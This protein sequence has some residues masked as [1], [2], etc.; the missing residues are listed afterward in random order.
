MHDPT[1][2]LGERAPLTE[3]DLRLPRPPGV[4]RRFW[5]RH[6]WWVDGLVAGAYL[7]VTVVITIASATT[8][9]PVPGAVLVLQFAAVAVSAAALMLRR[10]YPA[11]VLGVVWVASFALITPDGAFNSLAVPMALYALAVYR[12]SRAGWVGFAASVVAGSASALAASLMHPDAVTSMGTTVLGEIVQVTIVLLVAVL[13]GTNIGN[14]RRYVAALVD[15]ANQLARER[16]QQ[17]RLAASAERS[18]IARE[19]HDIVSHS[20]TVMVTVAEGSAATAASAPQR[21]SE[22]MRQVAET[23]RHALSDMRRMLGVLHDDEPH[24]PRALEPQPGV[25]DV[26]ALVQ[27]FRAVSLPVTYRSSGLPP[28]DAAVQLTMYRIVQESLTNALRHAHGVTMAAVEVRHTSSHTVISVTDD[29]VGSAPSG[30]GH[31]LVGMRERVALYGGT[32]E[33]GPAPGHGWSI[34]ATLPHGE[35]L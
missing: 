28:P 33:S 19:M 12:S 23:G 16:D 1:V 2:S 14:R 25:A 9:Y 20:L 8:T 22:A 7:L 27:T 11:I 30:V 3:G 21:A 24:E 10:R 29:G 34:R 6:P 5:A 17:A 13:L 26:A 15:L 35:T 4:V 18:R 32:L 31:G